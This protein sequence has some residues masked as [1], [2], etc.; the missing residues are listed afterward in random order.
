MFIIPLWDHPLIRIFYLFEL[1]SLQ[2]FKP[3]GFTGSVVSFLLQEYKDNSS[4][5][6][7]SSST[8]INRSL[9]FKD[10]SS[11]IYFSVPL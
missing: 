1:F 10:K 7:N 5:I 2:T 6:I 3:N 4:S 8:K 11:P 9:S